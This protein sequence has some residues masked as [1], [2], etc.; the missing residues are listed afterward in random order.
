M[1]R[2]AFTWVS[3]C[4][5]AIAGWPTVAAATDSVRVDA[6]SGAPR[7]VVDGKPVRARMFWGAPNVGLIP[8]EETG[9]LLTFEFSPKEDEPARAT[10][11]FRFGPRAGDVYLDDIRCVDLARGKR[12]FPRAISKAEWRAS[13]RSGTSGR[14]GKGIRWARSA[15]SRA[16]DTTAR[17]PCTW[18]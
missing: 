14:P 4:C 3:M 2:D 16:R 18:R 10:M 13:T 1:R 6:S 11:H 12:S 9:Q 7:I 5:L 8:A 17:P 15:S